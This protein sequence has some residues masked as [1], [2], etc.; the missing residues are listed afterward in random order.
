VNARD[1]MPGGGTLRVELR[2]AGPGAP[3]PC[4]LLRVTDTG[5]GIA[6]DVLPHVFEPFFTTKEAGCGTGLG[7]STVYG[8]VAQSGGRVEV[9]S[10]PGAGTTFEITLPRVEPGGEEDP[11]ATVSPCAARGEILARSFSRPGARPRPWRPL[12]V[13]ERASP[14]IPRPPAR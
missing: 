3:G 1:A 11:C 13:P 12:P 9:R 2:N 5:T 7:L 6:G 14:G 4:V 8:I 10:E